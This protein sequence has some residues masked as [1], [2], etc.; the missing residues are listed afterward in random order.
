M[1]MLKLVIVSSIHSL[2]L[3]QEFQLF[4]FLFLV[5]HYQLLLMILC[6]LI[7]TG[8][9]ILITADTILIIADIT[10][11]TAETTHITADTTHITIHI[12]YMSLLIHL[13]RLSLAHILQK[14]QAVLLKPQLIT[15][16]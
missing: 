6:L 8:Q 16:P 15:H 2:D 3:L 11:I 7:D 5:D 10:H 13:Q 9:T 4:L 12:D 1:V 14:D